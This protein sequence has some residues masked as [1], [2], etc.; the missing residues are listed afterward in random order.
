MN[1]TSNDE[2]ASA[3]ANVYSATSR[4]SLPNCSKS[5]GNRVCLILLRLSRAGGSGRSGW[6]RHRLAKDAGRSSSP[7]RGPVIMSARVVRRT[8]SLAP[9]VPRD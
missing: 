1:Q 8:G 4:G 6:P 7:D 3:P 9:G 2:A 5:Y